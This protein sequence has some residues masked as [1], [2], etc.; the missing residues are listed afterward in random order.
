MT[1][2]YLGFISFFIGFLV[3]KNKKRN[4]GK[5]EEYEIRSYFLFSIFRGLSMLPYI[6][7]FFQFMVILLLP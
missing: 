7:Q 1:P 6:I 2:F 3:H 4:S 5:L